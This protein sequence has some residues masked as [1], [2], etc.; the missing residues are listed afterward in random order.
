MATVW[1]DGKITERTE[2]HT[3]YLHMF[4]HVERSV[5]Q[6]AAS[7]I[8]TITWWIAEERVHREAEYYSFFF[9]FFFFKGQREH[10]RRVV[11][12][13]R[14]CRAEEE[15]RRST[16]NQRKRVRL[17]RAP[18]YRLYPLLVAHTTLGDTAQLR[19]RWQTG[20]GRVRPDH[21]SSAPPNCRPPS[22]FSPH[23]ILPPR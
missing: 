12:G 1:L 15:T 10:A 23:P 11:E 20:C 19:S 18:A 17:V 2:I 22:S 3:T 16:K 14:P 9:F 8:R 4:L 6:L 21:A 7:S 13:E 5:S